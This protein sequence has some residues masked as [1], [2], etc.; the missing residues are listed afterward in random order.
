MCG[1]L[2]RVMARRSLLATNRVESTHATKVD[3]VLCR[4]TT[5][6]VVLVVITVAA[7]TGTVLVLAAI[8]IVEVRVPV[9]GVL[10]HIT[11]LAEWS[12][13]VGLAAAVPPLLLPQEKLGIAVA[14][15]VVRVGETCTHFAGIVFQR[16]KVHNLPVQ[17][18]SFLASEEYACSYEHYI[19]ASPQSDLAHGGRHERLILQPH[20]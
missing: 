8:P 18:E 12:I 14:A 13:E 17:G 15:G 5:R 9:T 2:L 19:D 3:M 6:M 4:V 16:G 20:T 10:S 7:R 1:P 11:G